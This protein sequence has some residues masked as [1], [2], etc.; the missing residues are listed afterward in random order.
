MPCAEVAFIHRTTQFVWLSAQWVRVMFLGMCV[1]SLV[2]QVIK[3]GS[4]GR[5]NAFKVLRIYQNA[6]LYRLYKC[7]TYIATKSDKL[8]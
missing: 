3:Y 4:S 1:D 8:S 5:V 7:I 6:G 2:V